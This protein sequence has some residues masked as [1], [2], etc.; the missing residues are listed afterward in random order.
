MQN[1]RARVPA[2]PGE[3]D[4]RNRILD[5]MAR[6]MARSRDDR[7]ASLVEYVLLTA[8]IAVVCLLAIQFLGTS[9]S[10]SLDRS[11]SSIVSAIG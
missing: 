3:C 8:L 5:I 2:D 9:G 6:A 7:G 10:E 11:G 1:W 4:V